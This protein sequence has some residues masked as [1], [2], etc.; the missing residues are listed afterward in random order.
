MHLGFKFEIF[1]EYWEIIPFTFAP[2]TNE[3]LWSG[4]EM[5]RSKEGWNRTVEF[6]ELFPPAQFRPWKDD[7]DHLHRRRLSDGIWRRGQPV[8]FWGPNP[9][10]KV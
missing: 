6:M 1:D 7:S 2:Y 3:S 10:K 9:V 4:F 5:K 8:V